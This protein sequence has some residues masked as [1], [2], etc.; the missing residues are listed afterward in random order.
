MGERERE[1]DPVLVT[2]SIFF[3]YI[4]NEK[5]L[6]LVPFGHFI[7]SAD[8]LWWRLLLIPWE[9]AHTHTHIHSHLHTPTSMRI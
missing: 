9:Y 5:D 3:V 7:L 8:C 2:I 6:A 4:F 1:R